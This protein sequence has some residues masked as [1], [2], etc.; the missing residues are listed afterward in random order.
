MDLDTRWCLQVKE[1]GYAAEE[2][3][4]ICIAYTVS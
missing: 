1:W 4:V 2:E 3:S